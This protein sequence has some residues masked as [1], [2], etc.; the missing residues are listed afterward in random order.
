MLRKIVLSVW[1]IGA[2]VAACA[3]EPRET[4]NSLGM[5]LVLIPAGEFLMGSGESGE[6]TR[7]AYPQYIHKATYYDDELPQH[8]VRITRPFYSGSHEVT[9]A[10]FRR[11]VESA[12]YKT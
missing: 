7:T 9:N 6:Q 2:A 8:Q 5:K 11:F 1:I 4:T 12:H 3:G 10:Q